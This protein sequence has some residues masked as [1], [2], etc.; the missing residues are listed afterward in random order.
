MD[1]RK[2]ILI[3]ILSLCLGCSKE[4]IYESEKIIDQAEMNDAQ[5][6]LR[7]VQR[8]ISNKV[9]LT[10]N[11][12]NNLV[13]ID[14]YVNSRAD[15]L[16]Y[17]VNYGQEFGWEILSG[18]A[19]TPAIIA[20][21]DTGCFSLDAFEGAAA[22]WM[23]KIAMD[24]DRIRHSANKDLAFT[25]EQIQLNRAFWTGVNP[26]RPDNSKQETRGGHWEVTTTQEEIVL[27]V[28]EHLTPHWSQLTPYNQYCPYLFL[29]SERA[30]AGCVAVAGAEVL[31]YLHNLYSVPEQMVSTGYCNGTTLL[32][33]DGDHDFYNESSNVWSAMNPYYTSTGT[34]LPE[35][36]MIGK[37]GHDVGMHYGNSSWAF[38][39]NLRTNVFI[40]YGITCSYSNNYDE[41]IVRNSLTNNL[42]VIIT[43]SDFLIPAD[44]DLHCFVA[45]GYKRVRIKYTHYH[46][47]VNDGGPIIEP[48]DPFLGINPPSEPQSGHESYYTYTYSQPYLSAMKIN[49]GWS[50]QWTVGLNNGWYAFTASW[51]VHNGDDYY[52]YNHN[53]SMIYN[54]A[55]A[56]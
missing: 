39:E 33:G 31:Y 30:V 12:G 11:I 37:I 22:A 25:E 48:A 19:R 24:M 45:D 13:R 18:D 27:G 15:T 3:G 17:I 9:P 1:K 44:F 34:N 56:N 46:Y 8:Y 36:L 20:Q 55:V 5:I 14:P 52:D 40:P 53:I 32:H 35:A 6:S 10:K 26:S 23:G 41:D 54:F 21:D 42:P 51:Y 2:L 28:C 43:A 38:P 29:G 4:N 49:W 7:D 16:M 47:W 50:T